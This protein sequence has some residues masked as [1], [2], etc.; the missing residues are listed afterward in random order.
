MNVES[1]WTRLNR[2]LVVLLVLAGLAGVGVWYWPLIRQHER[3]SRED[4]RLAGLVQQQEAA[5]RQK[6]ALIE[7]LRN[8][9]RMIERLAREKL[10]LARTGETV[11]HFE[12]VAVA[13]ARVQHQP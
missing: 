6:K 1:L 10:G 11:V 4:L 5:L 13:P 7:A 3:M 9:P 12:P 8:D 2:L